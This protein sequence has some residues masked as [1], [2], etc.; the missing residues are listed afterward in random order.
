MPFSKLDVDIFGLDLGHVGLENKGV[1]VFDNV[2]RWRPRAGQRRTF[3]I[4]GR[5]DGLEEQGKRFLK[6][7]GTGMLKSLKGRYLASMTNLQTL[8]FTADYLSSITV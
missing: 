2:N 4:V 7:T 5:S 3:T 8:M 1:L 6:Q